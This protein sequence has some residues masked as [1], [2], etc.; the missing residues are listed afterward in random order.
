MPAPLQQLSWDDIR[1][2]GAIAASS[3]LAPAAS[4]LGI[5][6]STAIRRL[7]RL[8][9]QLGV[10]LFHRHRAGYVLTPA[11]EELARFASDTAEGVAELTRRVEGASEATAGELRITTSDSF[12]H[13]LLRPVVGT[14][15]ARHPAIQLNFTLNNSPLSLTRRDADIA[16][17]AAADPPDGLVGRRVASIRWAVYGRAADVPGDRDD[18][19]LSTRAWVAL[20]DDLASLR[21]LRPILD[22]TPPERIVLRVNSV[23]ALEQA[24]ASGIGIGYLPCFSGERHPELRRLGPPTDPVADLWLLTHPDMRRSTR[25]RLFLDHA[26]A[27]LQRMRHLFEPV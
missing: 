25:V 19:D 4:L 2:V 22:G 10:M 11:G 26:V 6:H 23:V 1:L 21:T 27:A 12:F 18:H 17:R 3:K 16:I 7:D 14:F 8:E 5:N 24:V 13:C 20:G 9:A 15:S